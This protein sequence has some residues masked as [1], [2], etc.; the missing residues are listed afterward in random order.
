MTPARLHRN[1]RQREVAAVVVSRAEL[2][3]AGRMATARSGSLVLCE[4]C[5]KPW[6]QRSGHGWLRI[7]YELTDGS[8]LVS[9]VCSAHCWRELRS[10]DARPVTRADCASVPRPCPYVGCPYHLYLDVMP[11]GAI[12]MNFPDLEPGDLQE[13]CVLDICETGARPIERV[14]RLMN[15]T[16]ERSR[17]VFLAATKRA[18]F[19]LQNFRPGE[20]E[21]DEWAQSERNSA[22]T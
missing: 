18:A 4:R 9:H 16:R 11:S 2:D 17:L 3:R 5:Q 13:S 1:A 8:V 14:A 20:E 19:G 21:N 10:R 22:G 6:A 12:K 7:Q 15:L